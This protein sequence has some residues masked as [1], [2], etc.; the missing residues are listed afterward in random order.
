MI[1]SGVKSR[2]RLPHTCGE[3]KSCMKV[4]YAT[5]ALAEDGV[6]RLAIFGPAKP[7]YCGECECWHLTTNA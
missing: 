3:G 7:Y 6:R 2:H 1:A 4:R 5:E